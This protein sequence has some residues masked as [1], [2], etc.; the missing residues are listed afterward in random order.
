MR[1]DHLATTSRDFTTMTGL[2]ENYF[3]SEALPFITCRQSYGY[4]DQ[5]ITPLQIFMV[6]LVSQSNRDSTLS[7]LLRRLIPSTVWFRK[8][9]RC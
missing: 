9:L 2:Y 8:L 1:D 3:I 7:R 6:L 4:I 5:P